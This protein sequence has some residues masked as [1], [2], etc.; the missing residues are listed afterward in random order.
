MDLP[1]VVLIVQKQVHQGIG[2]GFRLDAGGAVDVDGADKIGGGH[3]FDV[4]DGSVVEGGEGGE[5]G[6]GVGVGFGHG[7]G[8]EAK[9]AALQGVA[10]E[11]ID[12]IDVVHGGAE[13]GEKADARGMPFAGVQGGDGQ[14][15]AMVSKAR[16]AGKLTVGAEG[17]M[18][19]GRMA[20]DVSGVNRGISGVAMRRGGW[21]GS[22]LTGHLQSGGR[23]ASAKA[24]RGGCWG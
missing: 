24:H 19:R 1:T 6:C 3:G 23:P 4:A 18:H 12:G 15:K 14:A 8:G 16:V 5:E 22:G 7:E 21:R 2:H 10:I 13:R 17:I 20:C 9:G 11:Q